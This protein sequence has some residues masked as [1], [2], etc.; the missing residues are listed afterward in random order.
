[1]EDIRHHISI[2]SEAKA[3]PVFLKTSARGRGL[4]AE[5]AKDRMF[6]DYLRRIAAQYRYPTN[7]TMYSWKKGCITT[8]SRAIGTD[9]TALG[10]G[11]EDTVVEDYYDDPLA[12]R[13]TV[14]RN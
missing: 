7:T 5:P 10:H 14:S 8:A 1:M 12:Q 13:R 11:T 9:A 2:K 4:E 6:M 3:Q